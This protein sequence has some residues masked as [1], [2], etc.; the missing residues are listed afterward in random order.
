M[1]VCVNSDTRPSIWTARVG[2]A[3]VRILCHVAP[4]NKIIILWLSLREAPL[5][6]SAI[7]WF[8]HNV[9]MESSGLTRSSLWNHCSTNGMHLLW[10]R[11]SAATRCCIS[12][13]LGSHSR[14]RRGKSSLLPYPHG[15]TCRFGSCSSHGVAAGAQVIFAAA[16]TETANSRRRRVLKEMQRSTSLNNGEAVAPVW[17]KG[18]QV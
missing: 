4:M 14:M 10:S 11:L 18:N 17:G 2:V 6:L 8:L 5:A 9:A 7:A 16:R 12:G 3:N 15:G 1:H 13:L